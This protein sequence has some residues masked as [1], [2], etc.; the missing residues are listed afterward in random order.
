VTDEQI[1]QGLRS[2]RGLLSPVEI[3]AR[4]K[5]FGWNQKQFAEHLGSREETVSRWL[6]GGY[7][8]TRSM[9]KAMRNL[10]ELEDIK[11]KS[12]S[13]GAVEAKPHYG[14]PEGSASAPTGP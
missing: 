11:Q 1:T 7:I 14:L 5:Q 8:Q 6:R 4:L 3:R 13:A 2:H 12:G 9:D 10:F